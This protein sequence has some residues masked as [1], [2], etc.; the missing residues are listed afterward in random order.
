MRHHT[1]LR[2]P[3]PPKLTHTRPQQPPPHTLP[4]RP[5]T[6]R[7]SQQLRPRPT[8]PRPPP[9]PPFATFDFRNGYNNDS[10]IRRY[11]GNLHNDGTNPSTSEKNRCTNT[12]R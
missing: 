2:H 10:T 4:P 3:Q 6:H 1:K 9:K 11:T 7:D 12:H 5:I 8:R